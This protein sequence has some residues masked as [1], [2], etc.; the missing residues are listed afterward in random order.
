[1]V[2][3]IAYE[4]NKYVALDGETVLAC[5]SRNGIYIPHSCQSGICQSCLMKVDRGA[6]AGAAQAGLKPTY[7]KQDLFLA[8]QCVP[9]QDVDVSLPGLGLDMR[10]VIVG[11]DMLNHN[12]LRLC[13]RPDEVFACEPGQYLTLVKNASLA[14]SYSIA[15][16][17]VLEGY[18]ELHIRLMRGGLMSCFLKDVAVLDDVMTIRGPAGNCFYV[19][20]DGNDYPIVLAGTGTGLAPLYGIVKRALARGHAGNIQL[21]HGALRAA[22]LYLVKELTD[23]AVCHANFLY[24]P[25][26]LNG[27]QG[28][29]YALGDIENAVMAGLPADKARTHLFLC[30][31]PEFVNALKRKAFLD[32][33]ASRHIFADAFL[34]SVAASATA[35]S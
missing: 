24:V 2:V 31:A 8:C 34:P 20:E 28:E 19:S 29:F 14:R 16:D 5:L 22:D 3:G 30:G 7:V 35:P 4:G 9:E 11:K 10:A 18:I 15:N 1:V 27:A 33:I 6:I 32:A 13:L 26:V 25:C 21:F 23:L 17:P 12:V